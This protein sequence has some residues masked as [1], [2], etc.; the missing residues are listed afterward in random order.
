MVLFLVFPD[1]ASSLSAVAFLGKPSLRT[2]LMDGYRG[3][4]IRRVSPRRPLGKVAVILA[5][6]PRLQIAKD[7]NWCRRLSRLLVW[8]MHGYSANAVIST[9][10][11]AWF[12]TKHFG[13]ARRFAQALGVVGNALGHW[14]MVRQSRVLVAYNDL[15]RGK[16]KEAEEAMIALKEECEAERDVECL[17]MV[18]AALFKINLMR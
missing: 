8:R 5:N 11:G 17:N 15:A 16:S 10:G 7:L 14:G 1:V 4:V 6:F 12:Q 18:T 3:A 9:L 13:R 2:A